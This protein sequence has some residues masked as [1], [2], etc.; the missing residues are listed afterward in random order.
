MLL[1]FVFQSTLFSRLLN[2]FSRNHKK[3]S[4]KHSISVIRKYVTSASNVFV[5]T[6][7]AST[8]SIHLDSYISRADIGHDTELDYGCAGLNPNYTGHRVDVRISRRFF[9]NSRS[10]RSTVFAALN[11][12]ALNYPACPVTERIKM[13]THFNRARSSRFAP[14]TH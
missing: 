1:N 14:T 5:R 10:D 9:E 11:E 13:I 8:N 3:S 7:R 12:P 6:I 2:A 4:H